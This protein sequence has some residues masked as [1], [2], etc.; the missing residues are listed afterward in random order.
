MGGTAELLNSGQI[1][2]LFCR[3]KQ[4]DFLVVWIWEDV[5]NCS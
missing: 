5:K 2:N 3:W 1:L 4:E